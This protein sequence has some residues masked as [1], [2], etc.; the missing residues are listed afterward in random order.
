MDRPLVS[1]SCI[2]YNHGKY[3]EDCLKG[4][5]MQKTDF[6][7]EILIHDDASSDGTIEVIQHYAKQ[8][9]CIKPI[10]QK[11]NQYSQGQRGMNIK[12]NF[13]RAK[14]EFIA[15]CEGDDIWL[16]P[17]K[18]QKQVDI[19]E[20]NPKI[21]ACFTNALII[22]EQGDKINSFMK[23]SSDRSFNTRDIL[24]R[25]GGMYP[26]A[27]LMFRNEEVEYPDFLYKASAGDF[28]L[29]LFLAER[30]EIFLLNHETC[31]YRIHGQGVYT[32]LINHPHRH[33]KFSLSTIE[34]LDTFNK[35]SHYKHEMEIKKKQSKLVKFVRLRNKRR[36]LGQE[37]EITPHFHKLSL[38]DKYSY[39]YQNL[40]DIFVKP[41]QKK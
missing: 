2:T 32:E 10:I 15:L 29:L 20:K 26:T 23:S 28:F 14:G 4:F 39:Y 22:N 41:V 25:G 31:G 18:L 1:I 16:D 34:L 24:Q 7:F 9:S 6:P 5:L 36:K 19:M 40:R 17:L 8:N 27:S 3:I 37:E 38:Y 35:Y 11:E 12:Y 13:P 33:N 21:S 30:G